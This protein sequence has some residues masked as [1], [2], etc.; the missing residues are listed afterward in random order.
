MVGFKF[1]IVSVETKFGPV[2]LDGGRW[3][4]AGFKTYADLGDVKLAIS[5]LVSKLPQVSARFRDPAYF[6]R[7]AADIR[8][9]KVTSFT[10]DGSSMTNNQLSVS[11]EKQIAD[12]INIKLN[13][14]GYTTEWV[15]WALTQES[16]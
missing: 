15:E 2:Y 4:T 12:F 13:K 1:H 5:A 9:I 3:T 10:L 8:N 6:A 16:M 14:A 11:D 7:Q